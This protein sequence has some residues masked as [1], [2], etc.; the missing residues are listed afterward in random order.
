[1]IWTQSEEQ[2]Q[3][4]AAICAWVSDRI[5]G[6]AND[7]GPGAALA[8]KNG[9]VVFHGYQPDAGVIEMSAAGKNWLTRPVLCEIFAY[10]F[11]QLGCQA[12]VMRV[13]PENTRM[14][15]IASAFGFRRY[16]IGRLRGRDRA[17]AIFVLGDDEYR[18]GRFGKRMS[19]MPKRTGH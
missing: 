10:I 9:A 15:R 12:A 17:E 16:D 3:E 11:D 4:Y 5:W 7:F 6:K 1:M 19:P 8:V 14:C 2:P 18:H 13:A